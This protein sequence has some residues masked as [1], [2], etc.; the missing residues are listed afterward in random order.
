MR[1]YL[2]KDDTFLNMVK[3]LIYRTTENYQEKDKK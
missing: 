2:N 3:M 1:A